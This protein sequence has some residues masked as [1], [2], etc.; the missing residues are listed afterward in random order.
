MVPLAD[1]PARRNIQRFVRPPGFACSHRI[2]SSSRFVSLPYSVMKFPVTARD[3]H[4][5][6][7]DEVAIDCQSAR[8][9]PTDPSDSTGP[10][11]AF[12]THPHVATGAGRPPLRATRRHYPKYGYCVTCQ[13]SC[14]IQQR[15][16][17]I[18]KFALPVRED[19]IFKGPFHT[20][21]RILVIH[22]TLLTDWERFCKTM[23]FVYKIGPNGFAVQ[24]FSHSRSRPLVAIN[25]TNLSGLSSLCD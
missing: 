8:N 20:S 3:P 14:Q 15:E 23:V 18:K 11:T 25:G 12:G 1:V 17:W 16:G 5:V 6:R 19:Y 13:G 21:F 4:C 10:T 24:H 7:H 9:C 2:V 22:A